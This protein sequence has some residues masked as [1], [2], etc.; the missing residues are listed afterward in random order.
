MKKLTIMLE[1]EF[2]TPV[3]DRVPHG[4]QKQF[5]INLCSYMTVRPGRRVLL[6]LALA[7]I[8]SGTW[9]K[10]AFAVPMSVMNP[11]SW[12]G[13]EGTGP[14]TETWDFINN[15]SVTLDVMLG[16]GTD[17]GSTLI[18]FKSGDDNDVPVLRNIQIPQLQDVGGG[19]VGA[20]V[21]PNGHYTV[22][23]V[24]D[25][26]L[27]GADTTD[28]IEVG[29]SGTRTVSMALRIKQ[30]TQQWSAATS[31]TSDTYT[32][33]AYDQSFIGPLPCTP[34]AG[35][36]SVLLCLSLLFLGVARHRMA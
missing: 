10:P 34:D 12:V 15:G 24:I 25:P 28:Q 11:T 26:T 23:F 7:V 19:F 33:T 36:T 6:G 18:S 20:V 35:S 21:L 32:Y 5:P 8:W 1:D 3:S 22:T 31:F 9:A 30:Y 29:D 2:L 13:Y 27:D 14:M 4:V 17:A 16:D